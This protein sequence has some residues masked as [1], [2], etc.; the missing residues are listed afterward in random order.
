MSTHLVDVPLMRKWGAK[1]T[2]LGI[3]D[4]IFWAYEST[5]LAHKSFALVSNNCWGYE[6]YA[7]TRREYNTPFVGLFMM[8]DCYLRFLSDFN[9]Y[10]S[11]ELNFAAQSKYYSQPRSYPVGLIGDDIEIHFLHYSSE[12]EAREKW[13]RRTSRLKLALA[14][15]A[16]LY[17]KMCDSEHCTADQLARFH[18]LD[19]KNKLSIGLLPFKC[20]HHL[21][22]PHLRRKDA[23]GLTDGA[24]LFKKRYSYFDI[25]EWLRTG[26]I[27]RSLVAGAFSVI[28]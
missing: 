23:K 3:R 18:A 20:A 5:R 1:K 12:R 14:S 27:K 22:V 11:A 7:A 16:E 17:V 19:F 21:Q 6:L 15:G 2:L 13:I 10:I 24:K 9:H 25:T 28:S 8:P 4:R 26:K